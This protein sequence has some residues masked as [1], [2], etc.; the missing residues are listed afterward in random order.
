M[1]ELKR[2]P[3]KHRMPPPQGRSSP[4]IIDRHQLWQL[5]L[6]SAVTPVPAHEMPTII[7]VGGGKGGVGKSILSANLA[8]KLG[9]LGY[10]VLAIDLDLGCSNLHTH[11]GLVNPKKNLGDL[12][13][14][15][16]LSFR[17]L[18]IPAPVQG[19]G[20]IAGGREEEWGFL[21][22]GH[23]SALTRLYDGILQSKRDLAVDVVIL[24]LGAG[25]HR[26]TMDFFGLAH[27]GAVTVLPE[28]TSIENAYVFLKS[29]L[30][31]IISNLAAQAHVPEV[32]EDVKAALAGVGAGNGA[33]FGYVDCLRSLSAHYPDFIKMLA[34]ALQGR[35]IGIVINQARSQNDIDIGKSMEHICHKYFGFQTCYLGHL[36]YDESVWK[37]LRNRR[38]LVTDFP[39]SIISKRL[40]AVSSKALEVLGMQEG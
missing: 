17:D 29:T 28:P 31:N 20:F 8:A 36:N 22:D 5:G 35:I 15:E 21:L 12:I 26:H 6:S 3:Q 25:T 18:I 11:Y 27:L 32:G 30:W 14:K 37:S 16:R 9:Q 13:L 38:L 24:D 34:G 2:P 19:V 33:E 1:L 7:A 4:M 39:H 40:A 10:R 23:A